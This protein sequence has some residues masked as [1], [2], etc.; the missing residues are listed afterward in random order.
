VEPDTYEAA[1]AAPEPSRPFENW[2][3]PQQSAMVMPGD[4]SD[5]THEHYFQDQ[6]PADETDGEPEAE[7]AATPSAP[8]AV[9]SPYSPQQLPASSS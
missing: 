7:L 9:W 8:T 4:P 1:D 2:S 6:A 5:D 3:A